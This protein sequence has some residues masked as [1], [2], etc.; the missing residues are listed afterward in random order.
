M[1]TLLVLP[2]KWWKLAA[3]LVAISACCG[4]CN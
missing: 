3:V 4:G 2:L 1:S